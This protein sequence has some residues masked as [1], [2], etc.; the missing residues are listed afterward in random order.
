MLL[1]RLALVE[2]R[3]LLLELSE[4]VLPIGHEMAHVITWTNV[5]GVRRSPVR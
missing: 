1:R 5:I 4:K 2:R 3:E